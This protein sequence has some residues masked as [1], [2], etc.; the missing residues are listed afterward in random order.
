M[1]CKFSIE[2]VDFTN[3]VIPILCEAAHYFDPSQPP[4]GKGRCRR[5]WGS[6]YASSYRNGIT[7]FLIFYWI[8]VT[9]TK[10]YMNKHCGRFG[11]LKLF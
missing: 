4:F 1:M 8:I 11:R 10:Y 7:T 5:R 6:F 2:N 9:I 3:F